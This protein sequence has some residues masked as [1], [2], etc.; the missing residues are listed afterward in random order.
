MGK[1]KPGFG[2]LEIDGLPTDQ[3]WGDKG[4]SVVDS[5]TDFRT[6][7]LSDQSSTPKLIV[8]LSST[9][10]TPTAMEK[11]GNLAEVTAILE[12]EKDK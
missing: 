5:D 6:S 1:E 11:M 12:A 9:A 10:D 7:P 4:F 2:S 3:E 8:D